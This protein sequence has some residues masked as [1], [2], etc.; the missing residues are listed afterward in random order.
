LLP[1]TT[2]IKFGNSQTLLSIMFMV[3]TVF[4][5]V[6]VVHP[7]NLKPNFSK[8]MAKPD[9]IWTGPG[10]VL[11]LNPVHVVREPDIS[12]FNLKYSNNLLFISGKLA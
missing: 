12:N 1:C 7:S 10:P 2:G 8:H 3:Q 11:G 4:K 6:Q 9:K 5:Q